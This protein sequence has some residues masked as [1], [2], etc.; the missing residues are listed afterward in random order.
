MSS[1]GAAAFQYKRQLPSFDSTT[2]V[3]NNSMISSSAQSIPAASRQNNNYGNPTT[4][5]VEVGKDPLSD[6][7]HQIDSLELS[8]YSFCNM[9]LKDCASQKPETASVIYLNSNILHIALVRQKNFIKKTTSYSLFHNFVFS[10]SHKMLSLAWNFFQANCE[11]IS[12]TK[13]K[14]DFIF[15]F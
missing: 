10:V 5:E 6:P 3:L 7:L 8:D 9:D 4:T 11:L 13:H 14:P 15:L 12:W 1:Y 2:Y